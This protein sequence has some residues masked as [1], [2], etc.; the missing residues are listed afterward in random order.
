MLLLESRYDLPVQ[1]V[2]GVLV[3]GDILP[4]N[5]TKPSASAARPPIGTAGRGE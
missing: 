1:V 4:R 3:A 2:D 5:D